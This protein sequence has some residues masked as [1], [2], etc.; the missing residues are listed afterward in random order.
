MEI[1]EFIYISSTLSV[2][3]GDEFYQLASEF[4]FRVK[5]CKRICT[6]SIPKHDAKSFNHLFPVLLRSLKE[7]I[8]M[9]LLIP[10]T[11]LSK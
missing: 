6:Q 3:V 9:K 1:Q 2:V 7:K 4:S 8:A 10:I 5:F 11:N